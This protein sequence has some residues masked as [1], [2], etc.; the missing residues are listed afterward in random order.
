M[1]ASDDKNV[2]YENKDGT[3]DTSFYQDTAFWNSYCEFCDWLTYRL[4]PGKPFIPMYIYVNLHKGGMPFLLFF[5]MCYYNNFSNGAWF[6]LFLHGT[7]G[8][9]WM[10]KDLVFP[11]KA[12]QEP[13][14]LLSFIYPWFV[15]LLPYTYSGWLIM[16]GNGGD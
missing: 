9:F 13:V 10:L 6:Y 1:V 4:P 12:F 8:C 16:S 7:Y 5:F 14:T 11:D 3:E 15:A 2:F